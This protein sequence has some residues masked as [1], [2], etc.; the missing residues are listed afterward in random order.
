MIIPPIFHLSILKTRSTQG[1]IS[2]FNCLSIKKNFFFNE[3]EF[4]GRYF[5]R[6]D[7]SLVKEMMNASELGIIIIILL[8]C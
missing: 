1:F 5:F 8:L 4:S 3:R 7:G 2:I 6:E